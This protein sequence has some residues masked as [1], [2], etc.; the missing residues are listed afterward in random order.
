MIAIIMQMNILTLMVTDYAM[1]TMF[2]LIILMKL[3]TLTV[4]AMEIILMLSQ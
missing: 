4:M 3:L 2:S 1:E